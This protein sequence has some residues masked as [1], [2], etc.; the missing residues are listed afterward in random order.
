M[1]VF[2][3]ETDEET[4]TEI[5]NKIIEIIRNKTGIVVFN[6]KKKTDPEYYKDDRDYIQSVYLLIRNFTSYMHDDK[7]SNTDNKNGKYSQQWIADKTIDF[8]LD[9]HNIS[10]VK[11]EK[12]SYDSEDSD[13]DSNDKANDWDEYILQQ[14]SKMDIIRT[15]FGKKDY[16]K[17]TK[18][19]RKR[20]DKK[21]TVKDKIE[22]LFKENASLFKTLEEPDYGGRSRKRKRLNKR[23]S[24]TKK[25]H[26]K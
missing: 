18:R 20:A 2:I 8:I 21:K 26:G 24:K 5:I 7:L 3:H 22:Q 25:N 6:K 10:F 17:F 14:K 11:K 9:K 13:D 19:M 23:K 15:V 4:D 16:N 12:K 1:S